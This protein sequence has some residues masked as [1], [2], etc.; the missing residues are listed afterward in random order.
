MNFSPSN[1]YSVDPVHFHKETVYSFHTS[2]WW[3]ASTD[4]LQLAKIFLFFFKAFFF[5]F[6]KISLLNIGQLYCCFINFGNFYE[7]LTQWD[8]RSPSWRDAARPHFFGGKAMAQEKFTVVYLLYL[9]ISNGWE[10]CHVQIHGQFLFDL[11]KKIEEI[12]RKYP[13]FLFST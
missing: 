6:V 11:F 1:E 13:V 4:F 7:V 12:Y 3:Y 10:C 2:T 9:L 8:E 5:S